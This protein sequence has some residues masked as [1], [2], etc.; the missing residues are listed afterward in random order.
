M[1]MVPEF[2]LD[3]AARR[4]ALLGDP[5]RLRLVS[6]LH[7][8]E[9][10]CS[11]GELAEAAGISMPNASQHLGRLLN[12]GIVKRRRAGKAVL[13]SIADDTIES[14]CDIV[15]ASVRLRAEVLRT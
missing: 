8:R 2:V 4:F 12:G 14:I 13:Y 9:V 15:C 6:T 3:E 5:T 1:E 10:E 7:A 11:V